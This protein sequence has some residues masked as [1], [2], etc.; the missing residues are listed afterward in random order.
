M[1]LYFYEPAG[2]QASAQM[3]QEF[4]TPP[5]WIIKGTV[6]TTQRGGA[7]SKPTVEALQTV[8]V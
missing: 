1:L 2:H 7:I 4:P 5:E 6:S 3:V 8:R